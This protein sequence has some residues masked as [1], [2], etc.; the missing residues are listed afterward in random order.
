M[1]CHG[2]MHLDSVLALLNHRFHARLG[3]SLFLIYF[4]SDQI[5]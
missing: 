4:E 3:S 5:I 2:D 1:Q